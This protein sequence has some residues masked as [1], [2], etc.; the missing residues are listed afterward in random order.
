LDTHGSFTDENPG[1]PTTI[2]QHCSPTKESFC[3]QANTRKGK[4]ALAGSAA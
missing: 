4:V 2:T 3:K 1:K